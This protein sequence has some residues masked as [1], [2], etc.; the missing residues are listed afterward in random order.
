MYDPT[1]YVCVNVHV[2]NF[3]L[4]VLRSVIF[5]LYSVAMNTYRKWTCPNGCIAFVATGCI[6]IFGLL[7]WE[8]FVHVKESQLI[9]EMSGQKD[10]CS[11]WIITL[12]CMLA[13]HEVRSCCC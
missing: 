12:E 7:L 11:H 1:C 9:L 2:Y 3:V 10:V 8:E 4:K 6:N 13:I 5:S